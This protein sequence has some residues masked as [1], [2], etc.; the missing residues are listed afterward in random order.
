[1]RAVRWV[2]GEI[3][4]DDVDEPSGAGIV[5]EITTASIC[6]TDTAF[7]RTFP[8]SPV[9]GHEFAGQYNG[10]SYA[11]EPIVFCG[12]CEQCVTGHTNRCP[13]GRRDV[14]GIF[15]DGGLAERV[16][17]PEDALVE[18]PPDLDVRDASLV[19][20]TGVSWHGVKRADIQPGERV[21][22]V[23]GGSIGLLAVACL[24]HFGTQAA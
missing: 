17:I 1:M 22:V 14:I 6:G 13:Q 12:H 8:R 5:L 2:E 7:M 15:R 4:V 23:G 24:R 10:R 11:V 21:A 9:I 18:P 16:L 19:E 20:P 3:L